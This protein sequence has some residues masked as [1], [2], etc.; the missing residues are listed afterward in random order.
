MKPEQLVTSL[1]LSKRIEEL[2]LKKTSYFCWVDQFPIF[3]DHSRVST[4]PEF[5]KILDK[6]ILSFEARKLVK[7]YSA[8]TASEL[9]EILPA[10]LQL[11]KEMAKKL[12]FDLAPRYQ[13]KVDESIIE[14]LDTFP[15][16]QLTFHLVTDFIASGDKNVYYTQDY[17]FPWMLNNSTDNWDKNE[18]NARAKI[19]IYLLENKLIEL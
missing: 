14:G 16:D 4:W 17:G 18:A 1:E 13:R 6:S 19:L 11:T 3:N 9:G 7:T 8:F 10:R 5:N 15:H 12:I 2:G